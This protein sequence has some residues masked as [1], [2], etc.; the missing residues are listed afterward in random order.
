MPAA[1]A[2]ANF[3]AQRDRSMQL[4]NNGKTPL[5]SGGPPRLRLIRPNNPYV[6]LGVAVNH[7]MGKP[8]FANLRF[9]DWSRALVG[10]INREHYYFAI[11]EKNQVQGFLG[12]A[13]TTG[14]KA[15]AW[16]TGRDALSYDD[17]RDGD[18]LIINAWAASS[19]EV[20]RLLRRHAI[21]EIYRAIRRHAPRAVTLLT[22]WSTNALMTVHV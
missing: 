10:Q 9:G 18:C 22:F 13:L 19:P 7:L 15:E 16:L 12:W 2:N 8:A 11:D 21:S 6:A 14:D 3:S 17:S 4:A 20:G 5:Q 1:A